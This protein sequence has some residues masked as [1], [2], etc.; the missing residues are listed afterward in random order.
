VVWARAGVL[1]TH[2]P[3]SL[4][5]AQSLTWLDEFFTWKAAGGGLPWS[6]LAKSVD[7]LLVLER[8]WQT[9]NQNEQ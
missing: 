2:C 1:T 5:S 7:A 4:I 8:A 6:M 9:E 3:K